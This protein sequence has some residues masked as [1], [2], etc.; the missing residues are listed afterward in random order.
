M[1]INNQKIVEAIKVL[2][3]VP[4]KPGI[5]SSEFIKVEG[6]KTSIT[7]SL[8][9]EVSGV[10]S[11]P[12][13]EPWKLKEPFFIDRKILTPF[14]SA[15][16]KS[17]EISISVTK[18]DDSMTMKIKNGRRSLTLSNGVTTAG[19]ITIPKENVIQLKIKEELKKVLECAKYFGP[20]DNT[21]PQLEC[22]FVADD[23]TVMASCDTLIFHAKSEETNKTVHIP[24]ASVGLLTS[25]E[26]K[27][28]GI[29]KS[30]LVIGFD[31]GTLIQAFPNRVKKEFPVKRI[32]QCIVEGELLAKVG[33]FSAEKMLIIFQRFGKYLASIKDKVVYFKGDKL[34]GSVHIRSEAG[35]ASFAEVI[36]KDVKI[37]KDFYFELP[38]DAVSSFITYAAEHKQ[39]ITVRFDLKGKSPYYLSTKDMTL[40]VARRIQ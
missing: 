24:L 40:V 30:S 20:A 27:S 23:G 5:P 9:S 34:D 19:Y 29:S 35:N 31:C 10:V 1:K 15:G 16:A 8:A 2:D 28:I 26:V 12:I 36:R 38:L 17:K 11:V 7:M 33:T 3:L 4:I 39:T 22:V 18:E 13:T 14:V 25:S 32:A 37:L 21:L 6:N